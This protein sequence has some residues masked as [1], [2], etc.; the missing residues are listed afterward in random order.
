M[1]F[2]LFIQNRPVEARGEARTS[3]RKGCGVS[4]VYGL[5]RGLYEGV[6]ALCMLT[7]VRDIW[8]DPPSIP[9]ALVN[10]DHF[11]ENVA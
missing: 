7:C 4:C 11:S 2:S 3:K 8:D 9:P 5:S 10:S 1:R 6:Y